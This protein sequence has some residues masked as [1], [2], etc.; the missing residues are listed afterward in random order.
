MSQEMVFLNEKMISHCEIGRLADRMSQ[1][2]YTRVSSFLFLSSKIILV[3][4][5]NL[6]SVDHSV[7]LNSF[8][9]QRHSSP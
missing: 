7:A 2:I 1:I 9:N 4:W 6:I 5:K 8:S 3:I